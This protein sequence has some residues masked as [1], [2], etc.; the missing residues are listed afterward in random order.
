MVKRKTIFA[1]VVMAAFA[2]AMF[3]C[4][5][6]LFC[7][8]WMQPETKQKH[9]EWKGRCSVDVFGKYGY[10][11]SDRMHVMPI[12]EARRS[13]LKSIYERVAAA[14]SNCQHEI[15]AE[16][17]GKLPSMIANLKHEDLVD[18]EASCWRR[19]FSKYAG[20]G[21]PLYN[22]A[23]V[24]EFETRVR[25]D[26]AAARL[27]G[28]TSIKMGGRGE[29]EL[30]LEARVLQ[31]LNDY[32]AKFASEGKSNLKKSADRFI[33]EWT[34]HIESHDGYTR[35][36]ALR[37]LDLSDKWRNDAYGC[38]EPWERLRDRAI[39]HSLQYL[40]RSGYKPKWAEEFRNIPDPDLTRYEAWKGKRTCSQD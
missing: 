7:V 3:S 33:D 4:A 19:L 27:V 39:R 20:A 13:E 35:W 29:F 12:T 22:F 16:W 31:R 36:P 23:D 30:S 11:A 10:T 5:Y 37:L 1:F 32:S 18:V 2:V 34:G 15:I 25:T 6:L 14:Y 40:D 26:F 9:L 24:G 8:R 38:P 21:A 17:E 28:K